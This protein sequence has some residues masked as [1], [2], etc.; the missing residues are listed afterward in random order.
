MIHG[1]GGSPEG[2]WFPWAKTQLE[3]LG[4]QVYAPAMPDTDNPKIDAWVSALI[5][6]VGKPEQTDIFVGHSIGCQTIIRYL[7]TLGGSEKIDKAIFVAGWHTLSSES[8]PTDEDRE[9]AKPWIETPIDF[10]KVKSKAN[11]FIGIFSNDDP[12][13][14]FEENNKWLN[15][16]LGLS[17]VVEKNKG[18]FTESDGVTELPILLKFF[19]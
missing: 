6:E 12:D 8:I 14:P 1:W 18:H 10:S 3:Q 15:D 17:T 2:D 4:F 16:N 7:E 5:S 19:S 9:I 11:S 13:V